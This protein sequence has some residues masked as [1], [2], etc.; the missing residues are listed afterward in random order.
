MVN[1]RCLQKKVHK[2]NNLPQAFLLFM[3]FK[4]SRAFHLNG[5]PSEWA[6][7]VLYTFQ[8]R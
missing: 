4:V 7:F 8:Q 2:Q 3:V 1:L 5:V 6:L